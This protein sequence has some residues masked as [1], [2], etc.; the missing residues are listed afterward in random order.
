MEKFPP[1]HSE[2]EF[3]RTEILGFHWDISEAMVSISVAGGTHAISDC[4][5]KLIR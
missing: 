2:K 4:K 1:I 5:F 3:I